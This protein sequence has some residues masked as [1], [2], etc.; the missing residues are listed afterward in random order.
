MDSLKD[1]KALIE[2][3]GQM[4]D[5]AEEAAPLEMWSHE[6]LVERCKILQ[7][8][9]H[10]LCYGI[11]VCHTN[12]HKCILCDMAEDDSPLAEMVAIEAVRELK[13][14]ARKERENND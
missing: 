4:L 6:D 9:F 3:L 8:I 1:K 10:S 2:E 5:A 12:N 7:D 13:R 11:A 14:R